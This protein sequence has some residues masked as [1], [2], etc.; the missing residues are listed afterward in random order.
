MHAKAS[1]LLNRRSLGGGLLGV[2][3]EQLGQLQLARIAWA[4][5]LRRTGARGRGLRA[6]VGHPLQPAAVLVD[7]AYLQDFA[8]GV[9]QLVGNPFQVGLEPA[10]HY[11]AQLLVAA[12]WHAAQKALGVQDLEEGRERVGV[13]IVRCG[14]QKYAVFE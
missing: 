7:Q 5:V 13:A 1:T 4:H 11:G 6:C 2:V 9:A 10:H 3:G 12:D 14:A 8:V